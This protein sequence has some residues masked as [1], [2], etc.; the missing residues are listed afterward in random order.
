MADNKWLLQRGEPY[1]SRPSWFTWPSSGQP[2]ARHAH[3]MI[4]TPQT[5]VCRCEIK[6]MCECVWLVQSSSVVTKFKPTLFF[7]FFRFW[8]SQQSIIVI[9]PLFAETLGIF[10]IHFFFITFQWFS[11]GMSEKTWK[12][13][14]KS[15]FFPIQ[16]FCLENLIF[17][18]E[19]IY[20]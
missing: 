13:F 4:S 18:C 20:V 1:P 19:F 2:R 15:F 17:L 14:F 6:R 7:F 11:K 10:Y 8:Y 3:L 12:G 16:W 5:N 9:I